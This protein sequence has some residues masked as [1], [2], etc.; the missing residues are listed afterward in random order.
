MGLDASLENLLRSA[1][2]MTEY[3]WKFRYPGELEEASMDEAEEAL[4]L[5]MS[6]VDG[7]SSRV[8]AA[9]RPSD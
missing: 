5:A 9:A 7:V 1:A 2:P 8:P 3:A 4:T 6:V